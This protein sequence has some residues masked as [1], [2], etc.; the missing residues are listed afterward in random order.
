VREEMAVARG[1]HR[2]FCFDVSRFRG[3]PDRPGLMMALD[4]GDQCKGLLFELPAGNLDQQ[5]DRLLRREFTAKPANSM[6][7]WITVRTASGNSPALAFVM[8]RRSPAY[9]RR[10]PLA[11]VAEILASAR[12][13]WG[14]GAEYLLNTVSRLEAR[15]IHNSNLWRLQELI[16]SCIEA[17]ADPGKSH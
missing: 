16:A 11:E 8:N 5:F 17:A 15:G 3:T 4:V 1:W 14:T 12:G 2:A 6:P 7:E 10:L 13:H 9:C